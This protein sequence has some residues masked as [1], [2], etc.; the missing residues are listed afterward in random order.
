MLQELQLL[1]NTATLIPELHMPPTSWFD[2][3]VG[4]LKRE[5]RYKN[6]AYIRLLFSYDTRRGESHI[7]SWWNDVNTFISETRNES[8]Q[9][10]MQSERNAALT[11]HTAKLVYKWGEVSNVPVKIVSGPDSI[12]LQFDWSLKVVS[13]IGE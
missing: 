12:C 5:A 4:C 1:V 11:D 8:L 10:Q 6:T 3:I 13:K 7:A 9:Q 2:E